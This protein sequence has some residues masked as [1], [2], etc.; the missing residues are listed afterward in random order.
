M[1]KHTWAGFAVLAIILTI[2]VAGCKKN[3]ETA[4]PIP[5][6]PPDPL[7][8]S[9]TLKV[10]DVIGVT[11]NVSFAEKS[12]GSSESI[13]TITLVGAPV[14][15]HPARIHMNSA[16][17]AGNTAYSLNAVDATGKSTTTLPVNYSLLVNFDGYVNV[18]LDAD[19]MGSV[20]AEGDIGGNL[21]TGT[22]ETYALFQDSTSG[23]S[24]ITRFDKRKNGNTLVT[25]DLTGGGSLPA[26][27]YPAHINLGSVSTVG[28]P[29][30]K[31]TLNPVDGITKM[32]MTNIRTL[33]DGTVINYD[34]WLLYDGFMTI[35]DAADT[36]N[37]IAL[38]NI[39]SN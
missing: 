16:I 17:E 24:G 30:N 15:T 20:I 8:T 23:I 9:Y 32:S 27:S 36:T 3:E 21:L 22:S 5:V 35:H 1:K 29:E 39:G 34:N 37:V 11:G 25:V 26:G 19:T 33:N 7:S 18:Y 6:P 38:G 12:T 28:T 31:K 14:G 2:A 4:V 13:I 10:K